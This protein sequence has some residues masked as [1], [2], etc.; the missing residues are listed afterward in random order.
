[1][2]YLS[3]CSG[4]E[5]ATVAW[6][7]LG[8]QPVAFAETDTFPSAVLAAH[9][10]AVVNRGDMLRFKEWPDDPCDLLVGG[11]PCQAF[12]V[13]GLRKGLDDPRGSLMLTYLAIAERY[14]PRWLVWE[15]VPGVLSIDG[16]RPFGSFLGALAELG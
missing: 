8:W 10:P 13:A 16:G 4:I 2:R 12:S 15:N 1:M 9:Y 11:T 14:R 3:V 5:A 7:P 6:E